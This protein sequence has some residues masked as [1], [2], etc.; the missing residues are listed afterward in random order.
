M[1]TMFPNA[2]KKLG[3]DPVKDFVPIVNAASFELAMTVHQR[4]AGDDAG[5]VR[6]LGARRQGR[7]GANVSFASYG[8]GTPSHFLGEMLNRAA[9]LKMVHVP[10]KRIDAG[11][12]G[13][14]GRHRAALFRHR[15]RRA[16]RCCRPDASRCWRRAA[17]SA[18]RRCRRCRPSSS[19]A[20]RT[21]SRAPWFS[22]YAP[23]RTPAADRRASCAPSS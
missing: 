12:P 11:A 2:Y 10:Y 21:S 13:R 18:R 15:R 22:Y 5:R 4:R 7:D 9:G 6:C 1:M 19:S 8:A 3:Y 20:T 16:R 23:A 17:R 14:D